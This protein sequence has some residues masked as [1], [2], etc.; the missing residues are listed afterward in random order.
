M[1]VLP[2]PHVPQVL[3]DPPREQLAQALQAR[4]AAGSHFMPPQLLDSQ[5]RD[6]QYREEDLMCHVQAHADGRYPS[7]AEAV[8]M[9]VEMLQPAAK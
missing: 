5:L 7:V 4:A 3:L 6:L 9:V 1:Q 2:C 8:G